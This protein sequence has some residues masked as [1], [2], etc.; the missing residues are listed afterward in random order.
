[1]T[2]GDV[3][4][5]DF[6]IPFGSEPGMRRPVVIIQADKDNLNGLNT[7]VVIPLTSN[8]INADLRGNVFLPKRESG[9][10]KDSV[11]LT[12]QIVVVDKFRLEEKIS[13]LPKNLLQKIETEIDY[14]TKE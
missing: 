4:M 8:T 11:A 9:L 3:Y 14:V 10:S 5:L 12:H 1:M 13:K 2:R 6:G 7:K